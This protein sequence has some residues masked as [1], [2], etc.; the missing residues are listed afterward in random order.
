MQSTSKIRRHFWFTKNINNVGKL[1]V[2]GILPP[3]PQSEKKEKNWTN[4]A[5]LFDLH[6][7]FIFQVLWNIQ[8]F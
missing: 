6:N 4:T 3:P 7:R 1:S 2:E 8:K 5:T